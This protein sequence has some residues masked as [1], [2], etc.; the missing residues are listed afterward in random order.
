MVTKRIAKNY[1]LSRGYEPLSSHII[2]TNAENDYDTKNGKLNPNHDSN[3]VRT[4]WK[5]NIKSIEY[6]GQV[7]PTNE[8]STAILVSENDK[9]GAAVYRTALGGSSNS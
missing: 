7:I 5:V 1:Y 2:V 8:S 4:I 6:D 9:D 3:S